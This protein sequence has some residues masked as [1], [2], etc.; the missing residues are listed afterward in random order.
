MSAGQII[1]IILA[2]LGL[3]SLLQLLTHLLYRSAACKGDLL[4]VLHLSGRME[5]VEYE[6]RA[7]WNRLREAE[8][9][10]G[11]TLL[12][13]DDGMEAETVRL[14]RLFQ[15][16]RQGVILCSAEEFANQAAL[17]YTETE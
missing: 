5:D 13:V 17:L 8:G 1:L 4:L 3:C 12:L 16:D 6:L 11:R 2:V 7:A 9:C 15:R 14:C 10:H